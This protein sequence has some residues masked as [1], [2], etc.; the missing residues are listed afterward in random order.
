MLKWLAYYSV[1]MFITVHL[2]SVV[3]HVVPHEDLPRV[4]GGK[5]LALA[6]SS[7]WVL[8]LRSRLVTVGIESIN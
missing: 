8:K 2:T 7:I 5:S 1:C 3:D 6:L 4:L